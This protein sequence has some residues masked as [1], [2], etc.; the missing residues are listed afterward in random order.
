MAY[1][2]V[3]IAQAT[4]AGYGSYRVGKAAQTYLE[5]GCTWGPEGVNTV[6]Q[7]LLSQVD[8]D[9]ILYRLRRNLKQTGLDV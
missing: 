9:T 5:Q 7:D 1:S 6:L 4:L 3:A 2:S 8:R